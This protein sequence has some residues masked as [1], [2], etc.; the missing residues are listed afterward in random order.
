MINSILQKLYR[1]KSLQTTLSNLHF[2]P[3]PTKRPNI[4]PQ[5]GSLKVFEISYDTVIVFG[6]RFVIDC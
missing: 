6:L 5:H 4:K 3:V 1:N 2:S